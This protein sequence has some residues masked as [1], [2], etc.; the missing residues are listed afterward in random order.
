MSRL[1]KVPVGKEIKPLIGPFL[2]K[3]GRTYE[4]QPTWVLPEAYTDGSLISHEA[5]TLK[6]EEVKEEAPAPKTAKSHKPKLKKRVKKTTIDA[7][8]VELPKE[9]DN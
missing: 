8:K 9:E 4:I 7:P 3:G 5:P 2:L 6:V 1:V